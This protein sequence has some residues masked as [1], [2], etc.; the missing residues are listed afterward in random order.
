M[1][2]G[3]AATTLAS[4]S[5]CFFP[6]GVPGAILDLM[7]CTGLCQELKET[8]SP[9]SPSHFFLHKVTSGPPYMVTF[10]E[11]EERSYKTEFELLTSLVHLSY[12]SVQL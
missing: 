6:P 10:K 4:I 9:H 11:E 8:V 7:P 5:L 1:G 3:E 2:V 12:C